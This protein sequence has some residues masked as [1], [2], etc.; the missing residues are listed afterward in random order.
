MILIGCIRSDKAGME[1][2]FL[3]LVRS[4]PPELYNVGA[5]VE[6]LVEELLV[7]PENAAL[8][9]ALVSII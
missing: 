4:W 8:Q 5:I 3:H 6:V 2:N 7:D 1:D 9:R